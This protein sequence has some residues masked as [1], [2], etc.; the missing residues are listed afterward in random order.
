MLKRQR[1]VSP[2][3]S[4]DVP[5]IAI[6]ISHQNHEAKRRRTL[7][8]VLDGEKRGW[9]I[10][11]LE[12][13]DDEEQVEELQ[14]D[15]EQNIIEDEGQSHDSGMYKS[16]NSFLHDLHALYQHRLTFSS[17]ST[18]TPSSSNPTSQ[19]RQPSSSPLRTPSSQ[20]SY[21]NTPMKSN[22]PPISELSSISSF[23]QDL[24]TQKEECDVGDGMT[25]Y[26]VQ[27]V[28]ERYEDTNRLLG[29]L[30][31]SRRRE[32]QGAPDGT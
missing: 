30:V 15:L 12:S 31:L 4:S 23:D 18:S 19:Q 22:L 32:L 13:Y 17:S 28:K 5:L 14:Q 1:P 7:A 21:D 26:E 27:R 6:D 2:P 9:G 8:P 16:A 10:S 20:P 3:P 25:S 11:H 29:S 24:N